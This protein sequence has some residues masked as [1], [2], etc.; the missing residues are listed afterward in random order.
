[1]KFKGFKK[2]TEEFSR[3]PDF[4]DTDDK[5][6]VA[7]DEL[8]RLSNIP[9]DELDLGYDYE[10][11]PE[12][13][14][15]PPVDEENPNWLQFDTLPDFMKPALSMFGK[16]VLKTLTKTKLKDINILASLQHVGPSSTEDIN[17][18]T[19]HANEMHD[20]VRDLRHTIEG[21]IPGYD[22]HA[23]LYSNPQDTY[24]V[25]RDEMGEYIYHWRSHDTKNNEFTKTK[26]RS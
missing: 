20:D 1:M 5:F 26:K 25:L 16:T 6:D 2:L 22:V 11:P 24:L 10:N 19:H 9:D 14:Y 17:A 15:K 3:T 12:E 7:G 4:E 21:L 8:E 13:P 18:T 23:K